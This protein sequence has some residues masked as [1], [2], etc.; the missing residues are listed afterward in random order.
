[1]KQGDV[2]STSTDT[3]GWTWLKDAEEEER[4]GWP[5]AL[6]AGTTQGR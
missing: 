4:S 3:Y 6:S 1:M 5:L 2:G